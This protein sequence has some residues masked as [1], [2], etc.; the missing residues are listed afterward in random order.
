LDLNAPVIT[1]RY[2]L[3]IWC[4]KSTM[5]DILMPL[6]RQYGIN[7]VTAVGEMSATACEDLVD[8]ARSS[9][10]P[11][12]IF[13]VSDFDP[14]GRSMP[15]AAARKMEFWARGADPEAD[16]DL[17]FQVIP[18]VLTPEQCLHYKLPRTPLK[19]TD[20]R[21]AGFEERFGA[22]ATELDALEALHPGELRRILVEHIERY[23]DVALS[24]NVA[25]AVSDAEDD[26]E[27][28]ESDVRDRYADQIKS[29][30]DESAAI[31]ADGR[32]ALRAVM[33]QF[34]EREKAF[35]ERSRPVLEAMTAE[36][37]DEAPDVD[38]FDWPEP[39]EGEDH[40]DPLFDSTRSY[41]DQIARYHVYQ[42][43]E[44]EV[45][46]WQDRKI[47]CVCARAGCGKNFPASAS[48]TQAKVCSPACRIAMK[49]ARRKTRLAEG[50]T[51]GHKPTAEAVEE[52]TGDDTKSC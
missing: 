51:G 21:V 46:L 40:D 20:R 52:I 10:R 14:A 13:Y 2:H 48:R 36:L 7:V 38:E 17:D 42:G 35:E 12:R 11:A 24:H 9:G 5:N 26:L 41:V 1:Q 15:L 4:E 47:I 34:E 16:I 31:K 43:K 39:A 8:R 27:Q 6:G 28:V 25:Q 3:E 50:G 29:L 45:A 37:K 22:G 23:F 30:E 18:V 33:L 44:T 49:R 32:A 19:E